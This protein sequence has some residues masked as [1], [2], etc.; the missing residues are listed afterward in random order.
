M[1]IANPKKQGWNRVIA[2]KLLNQNPDMC[3]IDL[4]EEKFNPL[5]LE[6]DIVT[7]ETAFSEDAQVKKYQEIIADT[8]KL[9][10]V[11]PIWW[12]TTPAILKGFFDRVFTYGFA[13]SKPG[14][15][16]KGKL[17]NI[18]EVVILT[19]SNS[20]KWYIRF[21]GGNSAKKGVGSVILKTVGVKKVKWQHLTVGVDKDQTTTTQK[22]EKMCRF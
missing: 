8:K 11:Y 15:L 16:L 21:L 4:Y 10:I 2:E 20:P 12:G 6:K 7:T 22:V 14:L 9:Y 3:V 5:V 17:T 13:Y 1:I 18:E 19:T